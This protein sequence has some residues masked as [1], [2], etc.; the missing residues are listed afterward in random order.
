MRSLPDDMVGLTWLLSC[1]D[2]VLER[3]LAQY[4][5]RART[6]LLATAKWRAESGVN[7]LLET[8]P[9]DS[10]HEAN[11]IKSYWPGVVTG[12]DDDG[13]MI[14]VNR[15]G[16]TDFPGLL[17]RVPVHLLVRHSVFMLEQA[18]D[19]D[20]RGIN[21][22]IFD[23][24]SD[25]TQPPATA[26]AAGVP[27]DVVGSDASTA[28]S[29][30]Q[31]HEPSKATPRTLAAGQFKLFSR[32]TSALL[33]FLRNM[34][35][36]VDVHY[37]KMN[38]PIY[39]IQAPSFIWYLWNIAKVFMP[40]DVSANLIVSTAPPPTARELLA[41]RLPLNALPTYLGG[42]SPVHVPAGG[43]LREVRRVQRPE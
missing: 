42:T 1:H 36:I 37:P 9:A 29:T 39:I 2:M 32:Q 27:E 19:V 6:H 41:A 28:E 11:L 25:I 40:R 23:L 26:P 15:F 5:R 22:Q 7:T 18:L 10:S 31:P 20:P 8:W 35:A 21:V 43:L 38:G 12:Q 14:H 24:G 3:F 33:T 4:S 30:D 13:R 16:V 34:A 17:A